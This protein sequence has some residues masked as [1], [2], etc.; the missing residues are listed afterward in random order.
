[1][2]C[3]GMQR[4]S[5]EG[6]RDQSAHTQVRAAKDPGPVQHDHGLGHR[7]EDVILP[8]LCGSQ[9]RSP[10]PSS[11]LMQM[12]RA[13]AI[14]TFSTRIQADPLRDDDRIDGRQRHGETAQRCGRPGGMTSAKAT[15]RRP[16]M[17]VSGGHRRDITAT[18]SRAAP[19]STA[20]LLRRP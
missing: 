17:L 3:Q 5:D 7:G 20:R 16:S 19:I 6:G 8:L 9:G 11:R 12:A 4:L 14:A 1:M 15:R 18:A 2:T 10:V 13:A